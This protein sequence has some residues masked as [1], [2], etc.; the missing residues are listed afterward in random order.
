MG[1][2]ANLWSKFP[3]KAGEDK[4]QSIGRRINSR[5]ENR[6]VDAKVGKF[7]DSVEQSGS[8]LLPDVVFMC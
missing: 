8:H 5:K 7:I 2:G 3:E 4:I 1:K 6:V